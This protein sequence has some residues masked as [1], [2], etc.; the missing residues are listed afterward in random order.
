VNDP[1]DCDQPLSLADRLA[2]E[3]TVL[4]AERTLLAYA[5]TA[6]ALVVVGATL[7]HF[8]EARWYL[9]AGWA[10]I[11]AGGVA[12]AVGLMRFLRLRRRLR[13]GPR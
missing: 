13:A 3:R 6:L 2:V 9:L 8:L 1:D 4:A 11:G 12:M 10:S 7:L 5:R